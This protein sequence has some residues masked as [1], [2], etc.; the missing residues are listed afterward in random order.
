MNVQVIIREILEAPIPENTNTY[1]RKTLGK[2]K[3]LYD[4]CLNEDKLDEIGT[5]P[6]MDV[7]RVVRALYNG[8]TS[9]DPQLYMPTP[10]GQTR[11]SG[12]ANGGL[13]ATLAYLHSR[14]KGF[15]TKK[16]SQTHRQRRRGV[17]WIPN[18]R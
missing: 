15:C 7:V 12:S 8:S 2:V 11:L 17:I 9:I 4:E 5:A 14:G 1:D 16:C 6:L 3:D 13:T 10:N 18:R